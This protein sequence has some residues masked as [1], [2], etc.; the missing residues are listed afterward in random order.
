MDLISLLSPLIKAPNPIPPH[1]AH[2]MFF[3]ST[4]NNRRIWE[5]FTK[6][7]VH[8]QV[9]KACR[10][11]YR[12]NKIKDLTDLII[13]VCINRLE[14]TLKRQG[15]PFPSAG[16]LL[17][18][19]W[20]GWFVLLVRNACKTAIDKEMKQKHDLSIEDLKEYTGR[21]IA[22]DKSTPS[23]EDQLLS[24]ENEDLSDS[25]ALLP[26]LIHGESIKPQMRLFSL[27]LQSPQ[28]VQFTHFKAC[29]TS[30]KKSTSPFNRSLIN[31]WN[32]WSDNFTDY[33]QMY[34]HDSEVYTKTRNYI[35]FLLF[36]A[37]YNN[38]E[39]FICADPDV[40]A[41][42]KDRIRKTI[43][44]STYLQHKARIAYIV[45]HLNLS[46]NRN[47]YL[48]ILRY[49][50]ICGNILNKAQKYELEVY[51]KFL[52]ELH[53]P[54]VPHRQLGAVIHGTARTLEQ[55]LA[56]ANNASERIA[57]RLSIDFA[58]SR[59]IKIHDSF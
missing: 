46:S 23:P 3:D 48:R 54:N 50:L 36:G 10:S 49:D 34:E 58:Q 19:K 51:S 8:T 42:H 7:E 18:Y 17:S 26:Y 22:I 1:L 31:I 21:E 47:L 30:L 29:H 14:Y 12:K 57:K 25:V 5:I 13:E 40:F 53:G 2:L 20:E 59:K 52:Y 16:H 33:V 55:R 15:M 44:R 35:V 45:E 28:D 6:P 9:Q 39:E 27:L 43:N 37:E 56:N 11:E 32:M 41:Q 4:V 38:L 24:L